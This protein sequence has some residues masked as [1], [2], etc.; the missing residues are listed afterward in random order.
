MMT[1]AKFAHYLCMMT[2]M[3][4]KLPTLIISESQMIESVNYKLVLK[5]ASP[6]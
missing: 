2:P 4:S 3:V 5:V 6:Y 1:V